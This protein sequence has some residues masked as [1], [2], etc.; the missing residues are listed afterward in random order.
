[1]VEMNDLDDRLN[2]MTAQLRENGLI[3]IVVDQSFT[4]TNSNIY[5]VFATRR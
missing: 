4:L 5:N 1:M 2:A 3:E